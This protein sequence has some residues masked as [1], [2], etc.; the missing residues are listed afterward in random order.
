MN[1]FY[2]I[3]TYNRDADEKHAMISYWSA[4]TNYLE[5]HVFFEFVYGLSFD[6]LLDDFFH[7]TSGI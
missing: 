7:K 4:K 3:I 1:V 5:L 6:I 2:E